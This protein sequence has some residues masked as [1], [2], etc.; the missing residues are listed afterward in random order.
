MLWL[1][2]TWRS[3]R[4]SNISQ[5]PVIGNTHFPLTA[6]IHEITANRSY[7]ETLMPVNEKKTANWHYLLEATQ[8]HGTGVFPKLF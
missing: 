8:T 5:V 4:V 3:F 7:P 2:R 6:F 1:E